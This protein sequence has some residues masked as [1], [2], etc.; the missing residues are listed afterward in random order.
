MPF[1]SDQRV[2]IIIL[3]DPDGATNRSVAEQFNRNHPQDLNSMDFYFWD[4]IEQIV[5]STKIR[6]L[7]YLMSRI[8]D[9]CQ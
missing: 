4:H 2:K 7:D 1:T 5:Y 6:D 8:I 9:A 3:S